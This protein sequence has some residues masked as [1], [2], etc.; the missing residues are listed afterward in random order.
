MISRDDIRAY[1]SQIAE[2]FHPERIILFGSQARGTTRW[3][4]DV[5]L[6][7]IMPYEDKAMRQ[8]ARI[9]RDLLPPFALDLIV[10]RPEDVES[11][12]ERRDF[13]LQDVISEGVVLYD[14]R[15]Q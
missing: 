11:C 7:V 1:A 9:C 12:V 14:Q 4:S 15:N 10:R 5:D 13:F 3:G 6:L 2:R 8:A